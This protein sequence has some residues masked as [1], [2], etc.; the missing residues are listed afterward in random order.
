M[1]QKAESPR[2][3]GGIGDMRREAAIGRQFRT[4]KSDAKFASA[5]PCLG[6]IMKFIHISFDSAAVKGR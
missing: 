5:V 4:W 2:K 1:C 6:M 3:Q